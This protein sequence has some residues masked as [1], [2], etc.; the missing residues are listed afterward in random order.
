MGQYLSKFWPFTKYRK[1]EANNLATA[2]EVKNAEQSR[3]P[4]E[5]IIDAAEKVNTVN[6]RIECLGEDEEGLQSFGVGFQWVEMALCE[7]LYEKNRTLMLYQVS[8]SHHEQWIGPT[9]FEFSVAWT[10]VSLTWL[11]FTILLTNFYLLI[12]GG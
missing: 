6:A 1:K 12:H 8:D 5:L 9:I 10:F 2:L 3:L 4:A 7:F 11:H